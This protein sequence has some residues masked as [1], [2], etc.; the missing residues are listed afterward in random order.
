MHKMPEELL[1]YLAMKKRVPFDLSALGDS[2]R[3]LIEET[4][5]MSGQ[6]LKDMRST[7]PKMGNDLHFVFLEGHHFRHFYAFAEL[8]NGA[9]LIGM[10]Y[11]VPII[12]QNLFY[13]ALRNP[14]FWTSVGDPQK[15]AGFDGISEQINDLEA[16]FNRGRLLQ[17]PSCPDR[18]FIARAL[19]AT[20]TLFIFFHEFAHIRNGHL[21]WL[22]SRNGQP[23]HSETEGTTAQMSGLE[24]QA[25]EWNADSIAALLTCNLVS[26]ISRGRWLTGSD[27]EK[28]L[29]VSHLLIAIYCSFRVMSLLDDTTKP[30]ELRFH[31]PVALRLLSTINVIVEQDAFKLDITKSVAC[32]AAQGEQVFEAALGRPLTLD[33]I[34][35]GPSLG[36]HKDIFEY[37]A[38]IFRNWNRIHSSLSRFNR[39]N[40]PIRAPFPDLPME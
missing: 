21:D 26:V 14:T 9:G 22:A 38:E 36:G 4:L 8:Y 3:Y 19:A 15:E 25:L 1:E 18:D 5:L 27:E 16:L 17:P 33:R 20:S 12:F 39:G 34:D 30:L 13:R 32:A 11:P 29:W 7:L 24:R 28:L 31:P 37:Q 10:Y 40:T 2:E 6:Y 23:F 35:V